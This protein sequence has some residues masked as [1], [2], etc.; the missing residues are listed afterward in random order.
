MRT[1][2]LDSIAE[3]GTVDSRISMLSFDWWSVV[4]YIFYLVKY[5]NDALSNHACQ[6][7]WKSA[8]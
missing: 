7:Q 5:A 2:A 1:S 8:V 3:S 4:Y 6:H